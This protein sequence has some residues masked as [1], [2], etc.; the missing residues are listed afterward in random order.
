MGDDLESA[1]DGDV[2]VCVGEFLELALID[3]FQRALVDWRQ[4]WRRLRE[5]R[6]KVLHVALGGLARRFVRRDARQVRW[7]RF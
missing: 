5:V 6:V 4:F 1:K 7:D 3:F 2:R